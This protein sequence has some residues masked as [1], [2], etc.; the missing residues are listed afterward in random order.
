MA[1]RLIFIEDLLGTDTG[2]AVTNVARRSLDLRT[3]VARYLLID[4]LQEAL[5]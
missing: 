1:M 4:S 2:T 3:S 5:G